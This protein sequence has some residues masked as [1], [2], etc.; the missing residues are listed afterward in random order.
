M[1]AFEIDRSE[2][3]TAKSISL[4]KFKLTHSGR[5]L[6]DKHWE[7]EITKDLQE[8]EVVAGDSINIDDAELER[9]LA[10][11]EKS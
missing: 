6:V 3:Q 10:E 5:L 8:F 11:L 9:E 1:F 7:E 4:N 2:R